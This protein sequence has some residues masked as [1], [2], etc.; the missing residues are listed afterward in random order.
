MGVY[1]GTHEL[2]VANI[3]D[4]SVAIYPPIGGTPL[5][6]VGTGNPSAVTRTSAELSGI[7][8]PAGTG[9]ITECFF[10]VSEEPNVPCDQ[11]TPFSSTP[12]SPARSLNSVMPT[13][14]SITWLNQRK[15][16]NKQGQEVAFTAL[17]NPPEFTGFSVSAVHADSALLGAEINPGGGSTTYRFE[18]GTA[19]CSA[20]PCTSFPVPDGQAGSSF[21]FRASAHIS[22]D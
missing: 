15:R 18:Y 14:T 3:N 8:N 1:G 19:D 2:F 21:F 9:K 17:P 13:P 11:Q 5:P 12:K 16:R 4:G 20:N 7:V 10:E 6:D 22:S